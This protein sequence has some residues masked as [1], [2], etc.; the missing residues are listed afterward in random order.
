MRRT[1][2]VVLVL[3]LHCL[4]GGLYA[5]SPSASVTGVVTDPSK[6][7]VVGAQVAVINEGTNLR[8]GGATNRSGSY[9][10]TN[11][12]PGAYRVEVE[13]T[14][15]KTVLKP[16]VVLHVQDAIELNFEMALGSASES[17][18]VSGGAPLVNTQDGSV[19]TVIDR[20]FVETLPLNGRSFN[21]LL[22]LTPGVTIV[23]SSSQN[24]GQFSVNGQRTDSNYFQV[25]GVSAN[26][27]TS[28]G[29]AFLYAAGNGGSQAFNA[30]GGTSSLVSVDA[31]QE[32]RVQTSS[33]APEFGHTPGGQVSIVTRSG[34]NDFH[35]AAFE[36]FR[37]DVLDANDWFANRAGKAREAERQ[38][39]FGGVLGGRI[40]RD[41]TFFFLSYEGLRL[42]QPQTQVVEVPTVGLRNSA[43]PAA[44]PVLKAFPLPDDPNAAGDTAPFTGSYSNPISM[45]AGSFRIDHYFSNSLGLFGRFNWA[46]SLALTRENSLNNVFT[47]NVNTR[48]A[49]VGANY[50]VSPRVNDAFRLNFSRQS[51]DRI[52]T[53]DSF[54]G[55]VPIDSGLLL[56]SPFSLANTETNVTL[57]DLGLTFDLGRS[58][59]NTTS[60]QFNVLDDLSYS[61]GAHQLKMGFDYRR[62]SL[63][64]APQAIFPQ[65][66]VFPTDAFASSGNLAGVAFTA[67]RGGTMDIRNIDSYLQDTW[68]VAPRLTLTYGLRWE[69]N[70]A[71]S[72]SDG[73]VLSSWQNV[74]SPATLTLAPVGTSVYGTTY[75]NVAPRVGAAYS[76]D[77]SG[78]FV[79]RGGWGLFYDLGT[80]IA[81][82]LL[83]A[84][85]NTAL[86]FSFGGSLP[87]P[88][89]A[90]SIP[91]FP[92]SAPFTSQGVYVIDPHL[93]LPYSNL[94]NVAIEK[95]FQNHQSIS[96]T[97]VAQIGRKQLRA[98][99]IPPAQSGSNFP[100]GYYLLENA[101][102]SN[103]NAL[104]VQYKR[105]LYK[106]VQAL[107]HYTWSH[108]ID[109]AS[110]SGFHSFLQTGTL[111]SE[112][113]S[114]DFDVRHSF[115]GTVTVDLP[116]A[117]GGFLRRVTENWS[118]AG[119]AQ[120]RS[121]LPIR[122]TTTSISGV[123]TFVQESRPDLVPGQP[124]WVPDATTGPG[125]KLNVNAFATPSAGSQGNLPR[126]SIYGLG[127]SQIDLSVQRN[128]PIT[129]RLR[130]SFRTD[131]F[132]VLNHANFANPLSDWEPSSP[133]FGV[134]TQMLNRGLGGL[135]ALYQIGG[136]R[137]L[138]LSLRLA[139]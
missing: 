54:G 57:L 15:F 6:A 48:T 59:G 23:P 13:K 42:R 30:Y 139:F 80:G 81:P 108:S 49:T 109:S 55:A 56:S 67:S 115:S 103:Y 137:S 120:A 87:V 118:L 97:Y 14:G 47:T 83:Q 18:T 74:E 61:I 63:T 117:T 53:M 76:L 99:G 121:G 102:S 50:P 37:N 130:L 1:A 45:D 71:P 84:T 105:P 95:S 17:V 38:N 136:P 82:I 106:R 93:K 33:F 134:F 70:P 131:A 5:Q 16:S 8:Y 21:T 78:S 41:K 104:Q 43:V 60:T 119:V 7:V 129:E 25:D 65:Y 101:S 89:L 24:P 113:G 86:G 124:I 112:R 19:S 62:V 77:K 29:Q 111:S 40:F 138:Q 133:S 123:G 34:T 107:A 75:G 69:V 98:A 52:G 51:N 85:P 31:M 126:N 68:K 39:D 127:I 4:T 100:S 35:G 132:N 92:T 32:F 116:C 44:A 91:P 12:P 28:S 2:A 11:L 110:T 122:I 58:G 9:Y 27:G 73:A 79:L 88:N 22:Q 94:W 10:V 36:Y 135:N 46:P 20:N 125:K 96:V 128:F 72:P 114:S 3:G 26:F 90:S 66:F 64:E